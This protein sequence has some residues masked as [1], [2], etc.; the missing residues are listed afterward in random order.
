MAVADRGSAV[1]GPVNR[2]SHVPRLGLARALARSVETQDQSHQLYQDVISM[3]PGV[4]LHL[5]LRVL[6]QCFPQVLTLF[7]VVAS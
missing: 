2:K 3:A 1:A 6:L 7:V 5:T 4:C